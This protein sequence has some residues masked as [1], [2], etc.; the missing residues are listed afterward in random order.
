VPLPGSFQTARL[1]LRPFV[2]ADA[3]G[4]LAYSQDKDWKRFQQTSPATKSE[5]ETV[6]EEFLERDR[7]TQPS[8]ALVLNGRTVGVTTLNF[9]SEF[10]IAQVGYGIHQDSRGRGLVG[11]A[12][13]AVLEEAFLVYMP[14]DR[15]VASTHAQNTSSH[16]L[17]SKLGFSFE[18]DIRVSE[19]NDVVDG[20]IFALLRSDWHAE[21]R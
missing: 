7:V 11:E 8:Y 12:L 13:Q 21:S 17:L 14:L 5:A 6:V 1:A 10:Q 16:L 3:A 4:I 19:G 9:E 15:V 20:A 2:R 18:S